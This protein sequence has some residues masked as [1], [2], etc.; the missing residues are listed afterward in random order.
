MKLSEVIKLHQSYQMN[1]M[2][3]DAFVEALN[4]VYA[5]SYITI[6]EKILQCK[7]HDIC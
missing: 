4:N 6:R 7:L 2:T 5:K 3:H 1:E